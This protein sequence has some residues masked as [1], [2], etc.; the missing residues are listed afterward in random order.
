MVSL[1]GAGFQRE[2][3][4]SRNPVDWLKQLESGR[5]KGQGGALVRDYS[6]RDHVIQDKAG[7]GESNRARV[8]RIPANV[9]RLQSGRDNL[10][11]P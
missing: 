1:R 6:R 11:P 3:L 9:A 8:A 2:T 5:S 7:D 10:R 4:R